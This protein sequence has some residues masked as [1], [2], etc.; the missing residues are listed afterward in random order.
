MIS[1]PIPHLVVGQSPPHFFS[2]ICKI[3][4]F[5]PR[6]VKTSITNFYS[7]SHVLFLNFSSLQF[8]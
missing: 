8:Y 1:F 6:A 5:I 2:C 7:A 4:I 3:M